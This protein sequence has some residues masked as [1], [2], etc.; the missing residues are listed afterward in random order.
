MK[1]IGWTCIVLGI[2]ALAWEHFAVS[3]ID[4][5]GVLQESFALPLG[6]LLLVVGGFLLSLQTIL[7]VW[8]RRR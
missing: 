2:A 5:N 6:W 1:R 8:G 4:E 7:S 3:G